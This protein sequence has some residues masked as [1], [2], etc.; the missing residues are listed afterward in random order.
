MLHFQVGRVLHA[1]DAVGHHEAADPL[2]VCHRVVEP[3]NP[4][5]GR[6][7]QV[8]AVQTQVLHQAMQVVTHVTGLRPEVTDDA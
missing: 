8:K 6:R 5:G 2:W 1:A 4:A 7:H 3:A